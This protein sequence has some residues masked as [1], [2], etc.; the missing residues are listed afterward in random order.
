MVQAKGSVVEL[1]SVMMEEIDPEAASTV[2]EVC[3]TCYSVYTEVFSM[4]YIRV[5]RLLLMTKL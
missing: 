2:I 4:A 1:I 3:I 5:W